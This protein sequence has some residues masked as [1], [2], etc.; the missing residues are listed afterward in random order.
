MPG[1][2]PSAKYAEGPRQNQP[3]EAPTYS[4]DAEQFQA[5]MN[6]TCPVHRF[7]GLGLLLAV[8]SRS[9][10]HVGPSH[11]QAGRRSYSGS[12]RTG[13]MRNRKP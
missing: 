11:N 2:S 13:A 5:E 7:R 1:L 6:R 9:S 4:S 3:R 12:R 8:N 10:S